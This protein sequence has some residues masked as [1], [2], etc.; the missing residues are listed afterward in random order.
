[1]VGHFNGA[2]FSKLHE[3]VRL[4]NQTLVKYYRSFIEW[5]K[6]SLVQHLF[7]KT[8]RFFFVFSFRF[9]SNF[10]ECLETAGVSV[11]WHKFW[12]FCSE[13]QTLMTTVI[14]VLK[15]VS[16]TTLG[17]WFLKPFSLDNRIIVSFI[18]YADL[19][20]FTRCWI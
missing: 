13:K 4:Q 7:Y 10:I 16:T 6:K 3:V 2:S 17:A 11:Q 9:L 20:H 8:F 19:W 1:M 12:D 5:I 14:D 15:K 18:H